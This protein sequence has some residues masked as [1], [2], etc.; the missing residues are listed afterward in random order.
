[1]ILTDCLRKSSRVVYLVSAGARQV[2]DSTGRIWINNTGAKSSGASATTYIPVTEST[3]WCT[4]LGALFWMK[5]VLVSFDLFTD[6]LGAR[7]SEQPARWR[8]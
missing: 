6:V 7:A 5:Y 1:M 8:N 4:F 3:E 2:R